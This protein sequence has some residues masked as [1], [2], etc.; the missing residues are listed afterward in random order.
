MLCDHVFKHMYLS[1]LCIQYSNFHRGCPVSYCI[2][3][4][5]YLSAIRFFLSKFVIF[6]G[7]TELFLFSAYEQIHTAC[8]V[9]AKHF[10]LTRVIQDFFFEIFFSFLCLYSHTYKPSFIRSLSEDIAEN[11]CFFLKT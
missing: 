10:I 6:I 9:S 2:H 3:R 11:V 1:V 4:W 5:Q 7:M 8:F